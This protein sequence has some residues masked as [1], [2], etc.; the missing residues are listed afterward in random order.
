MSN[1][2][3]SRSDFVLAR[4]DDF[5]DRAIQFG[6]LVLFAPAYPLA[7]ALALLNNVIE[8]RSA[9]Y[10]MCHGFQRPVYTER[11]G[12]GSWFVVLNV[13]G[14]FVVLNVL[15]SNIIIMSA[16]HRYCVRLRTCAATGF[17]AVITNASMIAFVGSQ[18]AER[19]SLIPENNVGIKQCRL[20]VISVEENC[21]AEGAVRFSQRID[22]YELWM[23]FI[24]TEHGMMLLRVAILTA[25]PIM[26]AWIHSARETLEYR[27]LHIYKTGAQL[28]ME[29]RAREQ[30][31]HKLHDKRQMIMVSHCHC[32]PLEQNLIS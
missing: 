4:F 18:E 9:A 15:G 10:R 6:Y 5:N 14:K 12:I 2:V 29:Q 21:I 28:E 31:L 3:V 17:M 8:I 25:A 16:V 1:A 30:F 11:E 26:P 23:V 22:Y 32:D 24:V 19:F 27:V 7:P 13:L 20:G